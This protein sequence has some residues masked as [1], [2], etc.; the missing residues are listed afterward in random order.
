MSGII[1]HDSYDAPT[2]Q[3]IT[4]TYH[5]VCDS[6]RVR[7]EGDDHVI[8]AIVAVYFSQAAC[9]SD[10]AAIVQTPKTVTVSTLGN[11]YDAV[12]DALKVDFP[13]HTVA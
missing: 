10:K 6:L 7:R 3:P 12:V 13:N 2:G 4:D 11:P 9:G 8:T 5:M 1:N